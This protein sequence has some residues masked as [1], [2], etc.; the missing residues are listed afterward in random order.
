MHICNKYFFVWTRAACVFLS[1][2]CHVFSAICNSFSS[3]QSPRCCSESSLKFTLYF[4]YL[5]ISWSLFSFI[6]SPTVASWPA[7]GSDGPCSALVTSKTRTITASCGPGP[8]SLSWHF[9]SIKCS[10]VTLALTCVDTWHYTRCCCCT[11]GLWCGGEELL[12]N[13]RWCSGW[14]G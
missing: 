11:A 8:L 6:E 13:H 7:A 14:E 3:R 2:V 1:Y 9:S 4:L 10:V 5:L 12:W